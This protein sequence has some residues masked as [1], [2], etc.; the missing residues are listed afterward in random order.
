[1]TGAVRDDM[2][3]RIDYIMSAMFWKDVSEQVNIGVHLSD[4]SVPVDFTIKVSDFA[5]AD[6]IDA[7]ISERFSIVERAFDSFDSINTA[8][9][10]KERRN[11]LGDRN[12]TY[13]EARVYSFYPL[14]RLVKPRA[15]EVFYD[16]GCGT[17]L[18]SAVAGIM[19]PELAACNGGEYLE[20][21]VDKG[22][23]AIR[24]INEECNA[25]GIPIAPINIGYADITELD[26]SAADIVFANCVTWGVDLL[27]SVAEKAALLKNGTRFIAFSKLPE[28]SYL[29]LRQSLMV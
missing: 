5:P 21:L 29:H 6:V 24:H 15:G 16:L 17:G 28:R 27:E 11:L 8:W 2:P 4:P 23:E 9:E 14:L 18:P 3:D 7:N 10:E 22:Q 25:K 13:G 1:M 26:W 12:F 20:T 19:F